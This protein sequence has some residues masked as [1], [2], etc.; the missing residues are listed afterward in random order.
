MNYKP[1]NQEW[2]SLA[3][4]DEDDPRF[5]LAYIYSDGERLI[6]T[7]GRVLH[8]CNQS[9]KPGYYCDTL[10]EAEIDR[11]YPDIDK[12][13]PKDC[14]K[15]IAFKDMTPYY[16][17][18]AEFLIGRVYKIDDV[19]VNADYLDHACLGFE[20]PIIK[21]K[22]RQSSLL[23]TDKDRLAVIMPIRMKNN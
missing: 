10:A 8:I 1:T 9:V 2:L 4:A 19:Y 17:K 20:S 3:L 14:D 11:K 18:L 15:S 5:Y 22:D 16:E 7:N 12:V 21:Y 13:I 23:I 6:A